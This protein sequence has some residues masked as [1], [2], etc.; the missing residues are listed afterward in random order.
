[1]RLAAAHTDIHA[2]VF[3]LLPFRRRFKG[4]QFVFIIGLS[5]VLGRNNT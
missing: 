2:K 1:M 5:T 4:T 3:V